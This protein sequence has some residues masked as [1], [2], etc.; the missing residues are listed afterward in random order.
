MPAQKRIH[1]IHYISTK[2]E[3]E[4][5]SNP[6]ISTYFPTR[7][8]QQIADQPEQPVLPLPH[9]KEQFL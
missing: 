3:L 6:L 7:E 4:K 8:N 1:T 5:L 2:E 9:S